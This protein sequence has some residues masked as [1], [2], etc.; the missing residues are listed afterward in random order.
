MKIENPQI[1]F[2]PCCGGSQRQRLSLLAVTQC[3]IIRGQNVLQQCCYGIIFFFYSFIILFT[4]KINTTLGL[5]LFYDLQ[6]PLKGIL[7]FWLH[8]GCALGNAECGLR[9][10]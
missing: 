4:L 10:G 5:L 3:W 6:E 7:N 2:V 8:R 9:T 1:S